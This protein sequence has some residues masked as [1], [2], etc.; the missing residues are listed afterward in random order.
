MVTAATLN[1]VFI[2]IVL[3]TLKLEK[4]LDKDNVL[5]TLNFNKQTQTLVYDDD[6]YIIG[7][8]QLGVREASLALEREANKVG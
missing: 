2:T 6:I 4:D 7:R 8:S 3:N 5:S 1:T